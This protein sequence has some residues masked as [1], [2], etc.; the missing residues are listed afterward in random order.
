MPFNSREYEFA[1]ISVSVLGRNLKGL[2]GLVYKK[3]QDKEPVY[4][5]GNKPKAIQRGNVKYDGTLSML[6]SDFDDLNLAAIAAG[7]DDIIDIPA[8]DMNITCVYAQDV[9]SKTQ[10]VR[11]IGVEFTELEDGM[12]T[13]D[14]Y[15]EISLPFVALNVSMI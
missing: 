12:K 15:K 14:K 4:G 5:Q 11:I 9:N 6:K 10:T 2:R 7:Y 13:G 8:K 3:S 1:D